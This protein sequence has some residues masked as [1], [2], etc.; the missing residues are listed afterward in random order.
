[1]ADP[2]KALTSV[3]NDRAGPGADLLAEARQRH[4][5]RL[6]AAQAETTDPTKVVEP[7]DPGAGAESEPQ[8]AA[9]P[10]YRVQLDPGTLRLSTEV[11]DTATGEVILRIPPTYVDP[12]DALDTALEGAPDPADQREVE[13]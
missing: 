9:I 6:R 1:M 2:V 8:R 11:L 5:E 4:A 7:A 3:S 13:A 10:P 12:R